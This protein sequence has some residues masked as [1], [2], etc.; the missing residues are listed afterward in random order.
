MIIRTVQ[1]WDS[2]AYGEGEAEIPEAAAARIAAVA[3][4]SPLAD[5]GGSGV[6][7]HGRKGLRARGVV[8]L[9]ATEGAV[10]EILPK[11]DV[12]G[13]SDGQR[14]G[15]TRKRLVHMLAEA[16]DMK[17]DTGA[18]ADYDWQRDTLLEILIRI[19]S[20]ELVDAVRR[21][22]PRRHIGQEGDLHALR[23]RL[24]V[25]RQFTAL[26]A[27]PQRLACR[28]DALSP[29]IALNRI[30]KAAAARLSGIARALD[31]RRRLQELAFAYADIAAKPASVLPWDE[32]VLDRTNLRWR[33][34]LNLAKLLLGDR[35]QT[36]TAGGVS[37]IS[38]LFEMSTQ[39]GSISRAC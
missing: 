18:V 31:N 20:V 10:L 21:G 7:E 11:I 14:L 2:V 36:T 38:L 5:R 9:V 30:M 4:A 6:L 39:F 32:V 28:F 22:M 24:D 12:P 3:A 37:G 33:S 26:A 1:E 27:S 23:G 16:R 19:F 8:G 15:N 35:F 13:S 17:I 25:Q 34:L 29:D